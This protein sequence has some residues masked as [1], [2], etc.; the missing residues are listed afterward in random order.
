MIMITILE[1]EEVSAKTINKIYDRFKN[2]EQD[3]LDT[4]MAAILQY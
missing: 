3:S 4:K 2:I 1:T